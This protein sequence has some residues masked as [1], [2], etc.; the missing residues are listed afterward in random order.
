MPCFLGPIVC[1]TFSCRNVYVT[2]VRLQGRRQQQC[3]VEQV[4]TQI[5]QILINSHTEAFSF[6]NFVNRALKFVSSQYGGVI[7]DGGDAAGPYSP[8]DE[9]DAEFITGING[10]LKDYI[11]AMEAVKLRLGLQTVMLVSMRGNSYLQ[12]SGLNKQLMTENPARCAQ[13]IS[14]AINLIYALSVLIYPFMPATSESI[15]TQINAPA[16]IVPEVLSNDI[17]AGHHIGTP[18]H[19]F[20]KIEEKMIDVWRANFGGHEASRPETAADPLKAD[21]GAKKLSKKVA[22]PIPNG[23]KSPEALAL[24][25]KITEQGSLVR[26][27]KA[28]KP[29]TPELD[30]QIKDAVNVLKKLKV[31]LEV[32][33]QKS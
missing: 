17:L 14:R 6:G 25:G 18:V 32:E 12:S 20:K 19:L 26:G 10:L 24:E 8:N 9:S 30:A 16:R 28:T 21:P 4:S 2:N 31:D 29:K 1:A 33:L 22:A 11:N 23:P 27:L 5:F 7:P 15:L 3:L 13:V